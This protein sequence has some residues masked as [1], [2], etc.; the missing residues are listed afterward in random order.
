MESTAGPQLN[1]YD[2]FDYMIPQDGLSSLQYH[3][4]KGPWNSAAVQTGA[5]RDVRENRYIVKNIDQMF[6]EATPRINDDSEST[7]RYDGFFMAPLLSLNNPVS[8]RVN[9]DYSISPNDNQTGDSTQAVL[10]PPPSMTCADT[11]SHYD[12]ET[13]SVFSTPEQPPTQN[14]NYYSMAP[15]IFDQEVSGYQSINPKDIKLRPD[16]CYFREIKYDYSM[17]ELEVEEGEMQATELLHTLNQVQPLNSK[18]RREQTSAKKRTNVSKG[19]KEGIERTSRASASKGSKENT[20]V[21]R[22]NASKV[23]K[24]TTEGKAPKTKKPRERLKCSYCQ[25]SSFHNA[26]E[27]K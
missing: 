12:F 8:G 24:N 21:L 7:L 1:Y 6:S 11:L 18:G 13:E 9:N 15:L 26:S 3:L 19:N 10:G 5:A 27:L 4:Y 16:E 25:T 14:N 2:A 22:A 17:G 20:K 23:C